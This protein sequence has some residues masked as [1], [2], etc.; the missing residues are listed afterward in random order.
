[1]SAA[2][3]RDCLQAVTPALT[4]KQLEVLEFIR[5]YVREK[6]IAPRYVDICGYTGRQMA[7]V[8]SHVQ[9]LR[10][11]G[12][13]GTDGTGPRGLYLTKA[14]LRFGADQLSAD[15]LKRI[16]HLRGA[17]KPGA[18][19]GNLFEDIRFLIQVVDKVRT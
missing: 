9:A 2:M 19:V 14:G 12:L 5:G 11:K 16:E 1:M 17:G 3:T 8:H 13:V 10:N 6:K 4:A 18:V 7:T 15:D